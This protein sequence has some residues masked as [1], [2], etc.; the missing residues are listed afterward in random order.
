MAKRGHAHLEMPGHGL[1][2]RWAP[3]VWIFQ[4][5]ALRI[6]SIFT[7]FFRR[8]N[9]HVLDDISTIFIN[10]FCFALSQR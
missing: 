9:T 5:V 7:T 2:E 1:L 8:S 6:I 10:D 3:C 4:L